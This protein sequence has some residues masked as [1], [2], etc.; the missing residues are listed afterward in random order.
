MRGG[1][2]IKPVSL[3]L[4]Y[5]AA[6][7]GC[8]AC[9][10]DAPA[11]IDASSRD[12]AGPGVVRFDPLE[13]RFTVSND[14][15]GIH[16]VYSIEDDAIY[17]GDWFAEWAG[18]A[19]IAAARYPGGTVV[20]YWDWRQPTGVFSG[21]RWDPE[22]DPSDTAPD[23]R[24]MSLDEFLAFA[25]RAG[26]KPIL[27][28]NL[29]SGKRFGREKESI[30]R[31]ARMVEY[32]RDRGFP[33]ADWYLGNEEI[34]FHGGIRAYAETFRRHA[35]AMKRVD[36]AIRVFWNDNAGSPDRIREFLA[37]DGGAADGYETHGKW[38]FGGTPQGY[39]PASIDEW[40]EEY[41]LRDRKNFD[42]ASGGRVWRNSA[43]FYREVARSAGRPELMIANNEY[44][45]G[46]PENLVGFDR[47]TYGL[48]LTDML[49]ELLI[50]NWDRA[51][52]WSS[53]LVFDNTDGRTA[54]GGDDR[55]LIAVG[56]GQ[57]LNPCHLGMR[58]IAAA[59]GGEFVTDFAVNP[60][61]YGYA[62]RQDRILFVFAINK[63]LEDRAIR[64]DIEGA[65]AE[66]L[67]TMMRGQDGFGVLHR[68]ELATDYESVEIDMA[69]ETFVRLQMRLPAPL[70]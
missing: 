48:L 32:V 33:G 64:F 30:E 25:R 31:A 52:Y 44:G 1:S 14:L 55:G 12:G 37:H 16:F 65:T 4:A 58:L 46:R 11:P 24:W 22:F 23:S 27:G 59:Q 62:V 43:A 66:V 47:F 21:D 15:V 49:S 17:H 51:A 54:D 69:P 36:P 2:A 6:L 35:A 10:S 26:I 38:P 19:G 60:G 61:V 9:A 28:V 8:G 68:E 20:K 63:S 67:L 57:K 5:L 29:L 53:N 50:G 45:L 42:A 13:R 70:Q 40:R 3:L 39:D 56:G 34:H 7:S 41:P 18:E